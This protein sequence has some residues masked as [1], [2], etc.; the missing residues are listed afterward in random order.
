MTNKMEEEGRNI[1]LVRF[2]NSYDLSDCTLEIN[3]V[4]RDTYEQHGLLDRADIKKEDSYQQRGIKSDEQ[5]SGRKRKLE[6][7]SVLRN[8]DGASKKNETTKTILFIHSLLFCSNSEYFQKVLMNGSRQQNLKVVLQHGETEHFIRLMKLF[9]DDRLIYELSLL[10]TSEILKFAKRFKCVNI[11]K[12]LLRHISSCKITSTSLLNQTIDVYYDSLNRDNMHLEDVLRQLKRSCVGYLKTT[13]CPLEKVFGPLL[14]DFLTL[15]Q[16]C[17]LFFLQVIDSG[18]AVS[19]NTVVGLVLYWIEHNMSKNVSFVSAI[20]LLSSCRF[21]FVNIFYIMDVL[22]SYREFNQFY[23]KTLERHLCADKARYYSDFPDRNNRN[24]NF[25]FDHEVLLYFYPKGEIHL[26]SE[27]QK[28]RLLQEMFTLQHNA[29]FVQ[30]YQLNFSAATFISNGK[31][32]LK[33]N[34][35]VNNVTRIP[36][37][38]LVFSMLYSIASPSVS[39]EF[40]PWNHC[41]FVVDSNTMSC[42]SVI[43]L[44]A[45]HS[46]ISETGFYLKFYME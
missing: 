23:I 6:N 35:A 9:Y 14:D 43:S 34:V 45:D 10:E 30:G 22:C 36:H 12:K 21:E 16:P 3:E 13:F 7:C 24:R 40:S 44:I 25:A 5:L 2:F 17:L 32:E 38:R 28:D 39:E 29:V 42:W 11:M 19:E 20:E 27:H 18:M 41:T 33:V 4:D 8:T 46:L 31:R 26:K 1:S 37:S 15:S